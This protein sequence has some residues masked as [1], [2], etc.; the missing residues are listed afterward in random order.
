MHGA[1]RAHHEIDS[2]DE[3]DH[4]RLGQRNVLRAIAPVGHTLLHDIVDDADDRVPVIAAVFPSKTRR[5]RARRECL[6]QPTGFP[7]FCASSQLL[8]GAT[9]SSIA[10]GSHDAPMR[11]LWRHLGPY[12]HP[13]G[14]R[15]GERTPLVR[16]LDLSDR[17]S[18][19]H[20]DDIPSRS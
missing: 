1:R 16:A 10:A 7:L 13:I 3:R 14:S 18:V 8:R 12:H 19:D 20:L 11:I 9:Y 6:Y 5:S 2:V 15:C 4:F 17:A